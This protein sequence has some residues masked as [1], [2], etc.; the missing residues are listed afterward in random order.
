[1]FLRVCVVFMAC[2]LF[3]NAVMAQTQWRIGAN[4][5]SV[6]IAP[7]REFNQINPGAFVSAT[8][9]SDKKFQYGVQ[10][11]VYLNSYSERTIYGS[12]FANWRVARFGNADLRLGGFMGLMEYP[13][14]SERARA[15]GW[16]TV[17]DFILTMGPSLKLTFNSG[18]D[19]TVGFLPVKTKETSGVLTFQMS[20]PFGGRR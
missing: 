6:H 20:I 16:P 1:M 14:I 19:F 17:G 8:F 7:Q 5:A 10:L 12:T 4:M 15:I 11:G 9:R 18:L 13:V 3:A 2:S